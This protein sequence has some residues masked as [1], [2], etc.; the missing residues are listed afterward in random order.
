[1]TDEKNVPT[2]QPSPEQDARFSHP[3]AHTRRAEHPQAT[4]NQGAGTDQRL[5]GPAKARFDE[6]YRQGQ[7]IR[8]KTATLIQLPGTG[9]IGIATSRKIGSRPRRNHAKRRL[10][11]AI[12]LQRSRLDP[13]MDY[14]FVI[15]SSNLA[16]SWPDL[17]REL[18]VLIEEGAKRWAEGSASS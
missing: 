2:E 18:T 3:H 1:L 5:K 9:L 12:F 10:R 17:T 8:G 4:P 16:L 6:I 14:V 11:E 15:G 13:A 7:N